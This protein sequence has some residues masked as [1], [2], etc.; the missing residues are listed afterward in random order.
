MTYKNITKI[1]RNIL[2]HLKNIG[3]SCLMIDNKQLRYLICDAEMGGRSL[4]YSL[5]TAYFMVTDAQFNVLDEI[6][7]RVKPDNNDPYILSGQGMAVN[8][9]NLQEHDAVA[10]TYKQAK[11]HLYAFLQKNAGTTKLT[12]VGH[13]VKSD[14]SHFIKYLISEGSWEQ[15]CTYHYIDT[16]VVLQF[17]RACGKIPLDVDGSVSALAEHF[18][19]VPQGE[20]HDAKTDTILTMNI[21]KHFV[22]LNKFESNGPWA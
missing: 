1:L 11:P 19:I 2:D 12:P 5:L 14:I 9:I 20:L 16:S 18:G 7:L 17:L 10:I 6:Y 21:L 13:A 3:Y 15:F 22:N 8:K 4:E